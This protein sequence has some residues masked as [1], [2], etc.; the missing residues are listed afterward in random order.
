MLHPEAGHPN[1][2]KTYVW[3]APAI[4]L[5]VILQAIFIGAGLYEKHVFVDVHA[6]VAD[7][8]GI[9]AVIVLP[10][11]S[12]L[13]RFPAS[14]GIVRLSFLVALLWLIQITPGGYIKDVP[15]FAILH[16]P[17]AFLIFAVSLAVTGRAYRFVRRNKA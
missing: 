16:I 12:V 4:P 6:G 9:L 8:G 15:W 2:A 5:L 14:T 13:S 10:A 11:L 1:I 17:N 7:L 3:L